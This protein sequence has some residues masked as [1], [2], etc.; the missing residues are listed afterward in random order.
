MWRVSDTGLCA[1]LLLAILSQT[2]DSLIRKAQED[3]KAGR[4]S[5]AEQEISRALR[6]EPRNWSLWYY[7]G[8]ARVQ[9]KET[10]PALDAFE[11]ARVLAP[12]EAPPYFGMGLLYMQKG[13]IDKA[14]E[15]YR[16]G[17]V[18]D[19]NDVAANQN[20]ALLL[21]QKGGFR[22]AVGP[23]LRLKRMSGDVSTR[24]ALI[25]AYLKAGMRSEG[26]DEI[27]QFLKAPLAGMAVDLSLAKLLAADRE[28]EAAAEILRHATATW[29]NSPE[30]HGELG[31]LLT[32]REQYEDG[33]R[34]LGRAAQ[35]DPNSAK[36]ALGLGEAL[37]RW[38]HDPIALQYLLAIREKFGSLPIYQ[39]QLGLAYFYLTR[40]P[41]AVRAFESLAGEEPKSS[42][43]QYFLGGSYQ[44]MGKLKKAED[45]YKKAIALN[46]RE[47]SY[48]TTLASLIEKENPADLAEPVHLSEQALALRPTDLE[49]RLILA[50]CSERQGKLAEA[51]QWLEEAVASNPDSHNA[52]VALARVYYHQG[53]V[54]D[55]ERQA[56][57]A[58]KLEADKLSMISPWGPP[59][60]GGP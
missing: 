24:A 17:L 13:D 29:P 32:Q 33:V 39:F 16:E 31:L 59:E 51:Q 20:Y 1:W 3:F 43:V 54:Q 21:M 34:E 26:E 50:S 7:L 35:L 53:R 23:L 22:D 60:N 38:R 47:A 12:Q 42:R 37:L 2:P 19:P 40:Y 44:A 18:R 30:P 14:L 28:E 41:M 5:Q 36:Y 58:A 15:T 56:A 52:H 27:D 55:A 46:P 49:G 10:G 57:M 4:Y 6:A 45:C 25:E 8:A 48:Y 9:L 11:K